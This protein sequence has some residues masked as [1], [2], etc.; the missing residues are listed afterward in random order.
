MCMEKCK[1]TA[2]DSI[3][4]VPLCMYVYVADL[5]IIIPFVHD[6]TNSR[7]LYSLVVSINNPIIDI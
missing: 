2:M 4:D 5:I 7:I 3:P 1:Y 6:V